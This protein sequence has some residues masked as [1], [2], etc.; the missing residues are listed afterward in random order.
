MSVILPLSPAWFKARRV[1][2]SAP[3]F[4][5]RVEEML[6]RDPEIGREAALAVAIG[7]P[8]P[9]RKP[10]VH[11]FG[12]VTDPLVRQ[13]AVHLTRRLAEGTVEVVDDVVV[14]EPRNRKGSG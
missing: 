7:R 11:I 13:R 12:Q 14:R 3:Y 5:A 1:F 9:F 8:G 6:E 2:R 10:E 4:Q